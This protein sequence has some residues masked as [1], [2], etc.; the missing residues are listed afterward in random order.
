M[1]K[2]EY[3]ILTLREQILL[4]PQIY[5][6]STL[7]ITRRERLF[8]DDGFTFKMIST[9][10]AVENIFLEILANASDNIIRSKDAN[11]HTGPIIIQM[12]RRKIMIQNGGITIPI[13]NTKADLSKISGHPKELLNPTLIF[14]HLLTSSNYDD[15]EARFTSGRH[16]LGCKLTSV[17]SSEFN[18]VV[19]DVDN[20]KHF[21]Q[22]WTNNLSYTSG[23]KVESIKSGSIN[24][25][26]VTYNLDF[27]R[28]EGID[29]Y[30]DEVISLYMRHAAD[31]A[32]TTGNYVIFKSSL[33]EHT[34]N[35]V[36]IT[37]YALLFPGIENSVTHTQDNIQL[38]LVDSPNTS[39]TVSFINSIQTREGGV[40]IDSVYD[41]IKGPILEQI[42]GGKTM[43]MV[44]GRKTTKFS[45]TLRDLKPHIGIIMSCRLANPQ[46]SEQTKERLLGPKIRLSLPPTVFTKIKK[47]KLMGVLSETLKNKQRKSLGKSETKGKKKN[48]KVIKAD[49]ANKAGTKQSHDCN[50][51]LT[52][53]LSAS[54]YIDVYLSTGSKSWRNTNGVYPLKG[55]L[56][57]LRKATPLQLAENDEFNGIKTMLGLREEVDYSI[58]RNFRAL[59]YGKV[60][61]AVDADVDGK[62]IA[63]LIINLFENKWKELMKREY[64]LLL[65]TPIIRVWS[66]SRSTK[67]YNKEDYNRW[68]KSRR[69]TKIKYYKGLGSSNSKDI[70]EDY[71]DPRQT[72]L[73]HDN[74]ATATIEMV[75]DKEHSDQRKEWLSNPPSNPPE[76]EIDET[77]TDRC[78]ISDYLNY[79]QI[80]FSLVDNGRSIAKITDGFKTSQRKIIWMCKL[81]WGTK[82]GVKAKELKV[83]QLATK[84]A[85]KLGYHYG[86]NN[87]SGA[88]VH[89]AQSF[90][91]TN[92]LPLIEDDGNYGSRYKNGTWASPRYIFTRPRWS[93]NLIFKDE[94]IPLFDYVIEEDEK[95]EPTTLLPII[96]LHLV[97][98]SKGIGTAY[99]S[100]IPNHNPIDVCNWIL[101]KLDG[102][103]LPVLKPWYRGFKGNIDVVSRKA[104][105]EMKND[106]IEEEHE[107]SENKGKFSMVSKGV[108]KV[109]SNND[110][111]ITEIPVTQFYVQYKKHLE[112]LR[113]DGKITDFNNTCSVNTCEFNIIGF[114][115]EPTHESLK[116]IRSV[117]L[118]NMVLLNEE[119]FPHRYTCA[120]EIME[121]FYAFRIKYYIKRRLYMI[122]KLEDD[123]RAISLKLKLVLLV[124]EKR[125][126][127][128]HKRIRVIEKELKEYEIPIEIFKR[129]SLSNCTFEEVETLR[130]KIENLVTSKNNII[131]ISHVEMWIRDINEFIHEYKR[132]I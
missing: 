13:E 15:T 5:L 34:F 107:I 117:G 1:A 124:A 66:G 70:Q 86:E 51:W 38:T 2:P 76:I 45:L 14:G 71:R 103:V 21:E 74:E 9:P 79:E 7:S 61:L 60:M 115:D 102:R 16:G 68:N 72:I 85:E 114:K 87:L 89:L 106:E 59:R 36:T 132:R 54:G 127:P 22:T 20:K 91:G 80:Q 112:S 98:G 101:A 32:F 65:R 4:R 129:V 99:S 50:L 24:M 42:N 8:I 3:D 93:F 63:A 130:R 33:G 97:N 84:V 39:F 96:P 30:S 113:E 37:K 116:L 108:F 75:F 131:E 120:Q 25:V 57:N 67:F 77:G 81:F 105:K 119:D 126:D 111:I 6:N 69:T 12:D 29:E 55:K 18:V 78:T 73:I 31:V 62:H 118:G 94:D 121:V 53:G 56:I 52:E 28:F 40:H 110:I 19:D 122:S 123:I 46:F 90:T 125:Y 26:R 10:K 92:N 104:V 100:T 109:N 64:V 82:S 95:C 49:D 17:F 58:E 35:S 128:L 23:P 47:W 83:A 27:D 11:I 41:V 48:V 44:S 88:I 43:K